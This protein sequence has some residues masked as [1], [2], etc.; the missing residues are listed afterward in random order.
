MIV[1][2]EQLW[3]E[4]TNEKIPARRCT[5]D[6]EW[7]NMI[8]LQKSG[9]IECEMRI[10]FRRAKSVERV[11]GLVRPRRGDHSVCGSESR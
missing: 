3:A 5:W 4:D 11:Q 1:I 7:V 9:R 10:Q 8:F 6:A 2:Y